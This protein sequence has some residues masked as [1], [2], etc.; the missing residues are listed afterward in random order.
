M[1][2]LPFVK[3]SGRTKADEGRVV[4]TVGHTQPQAVDSTLLDMRR[5][6]VVV[7]MYVLSSRQLNRSCTRRASR[8]EIQGMECLLEADSSDCGGI[9]R[10]HEEQKKA[11]ESVMER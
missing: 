9:A 2:S 6:C 1:V 3:S 11:R 4:A 10:A 8:D 7:V 5:S